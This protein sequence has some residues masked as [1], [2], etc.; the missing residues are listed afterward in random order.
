[1]CQSDE[2]NAPFEFIYSKIELRDSMIISLNV[3]RQFP[4]RSA[5]NFIS[6]IREN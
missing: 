2:F 3:I 1:M 4:F 6:T 5:L